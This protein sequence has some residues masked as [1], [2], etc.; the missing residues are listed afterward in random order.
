MEHAFTLA[1]LSARRRPQP[2]ELSALTGIIPGRH[3]FY[4]MAT[5]ENGETGQAPESRTLGDLLYAIQSV[6]PMSEAVWVSMVRSIAAGDQLALHAIYEKTQNR[7][8]F[9]NAHHQE[10]GNC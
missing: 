9:D 3:D 5:G 6:G 7:F 2:V 10:S 4:V 8:Y 1:Y